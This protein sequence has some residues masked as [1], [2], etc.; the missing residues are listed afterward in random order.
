M[1]RCDHCKTPAKSRVLHEGEFWC[2]PCHQLAKQEG[3]NTGEATAIARDEIPGGMWVENYG[4][5]PVKVYSHSERRRLLKQIRYDKTTGQP[6]VLTEK[7][8]FAPMPGT[9][10][11]AAGIPNPIGY[12]DLSAAAIIARNGRA[13]LDPDE[14][15]DSLAGGPRLDRA[16]PDD[17]PNEP[18]YRV[19]GVRYFSYLED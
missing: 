13:S 9:D 19:P 5:D 17:I 18:G 12:R 11:D 7:E 6:Y 2:W 16:D 10:K 1:I 3:A 4:P 14:T 15:V 8:N